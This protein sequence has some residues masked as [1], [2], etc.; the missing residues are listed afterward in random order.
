MFIR[1]HNLPDLYSALTY[2]RQFL[3]FDGWLRPVSC[4]R[5]G[6]GATATTAA[7]PAAAAA[8]TTAAATATAAWNDAAAGWRPGGAARRPS[9]GSGAHAGDC[10]PLFGS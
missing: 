9:A 5:P 3:I 8:T 2:I 7:G 6:P 4:F 1:V 10:S